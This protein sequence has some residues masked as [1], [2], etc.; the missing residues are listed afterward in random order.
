MAAGLSGMGVYVLGIALSAVLTY[1]NA[2]VPVTDLLDGLSRYLLAVPSSFLAVLALRFRSLQASQTAQQ[3][4]SRYLT[5]AAVGFGIYG[6]THFVIHPLAMFP[7]NIINTDTFRAVTGFPIQI[8]RTLAAVLITLCLVGAAQETGKER[9]KQLVSAQQ[10]RL[11]ALEQIRIE[12]SKREEMRRELLRHTVQAQE[13]E[14]ARIARELHDETS[15]ALTAYSLNL[16]ALRKT[17]KEHPESKEMIDRLQALCRQMS[18]GLYRLV[19]DLRPAQ[20][21]DLGLIPALEFLQESHRSAAL[22]VEMTVTGKRR[23]I[24]PVVE[25]VLFRVAQEALNNIVRH[26]GAR[27]ASMQ[28]GYKNQEISLEIIDTGKGFDVERNFAPPH[29]W[30][31]V[32]MRE[33]VEA[34][35]GM[36]QIDSQP[37]KGT[38]VEVTIPVYDII[39]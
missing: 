10:E 37:G 22:E 32:G 29:G 5:W 23:R 30:G 9:Q 35:G 25:T 12:L 19:H 2:V 18:Q 4:L 16:A 27:S 26:S 1:R 39:P 33:R 38:R 6:L 31:L 20:L 8:I 14:R 13:E 28:L 24:D 15:Q 17:L 7:A 36:L 34:V 11:E 3:R 21:D